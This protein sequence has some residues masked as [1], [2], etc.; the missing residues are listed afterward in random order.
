MEIFY[1]GLNNQIPYKSFETGHNDFQKHYLLV[2]LVVWLDIF[3]TSFR[4]FSY[5]IKF[6]TRFIM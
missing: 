2:Y 3:I 4:E 6:N 1:L 5:G